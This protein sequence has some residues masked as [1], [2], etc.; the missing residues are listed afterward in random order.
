MHTCMCKDVHLA[1]TRDHIPDHLWWAGGEWS[2]GGSCSKQ[3]GGASRNEGPWDQIPCPPPLQRQVWSVC[4]LPGLNRWHQ[5][6]CTRLA[7][8]LCDVHPHTRPA[9][10]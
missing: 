6:H 10:C 2:W 8:A 4:G 7:L 9:L 5:L 1:H 3:G